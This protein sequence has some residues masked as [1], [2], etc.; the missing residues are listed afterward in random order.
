MAAPTQAGS[1]DKGRVS[2]TCRAMVPAKQ[3]GGSVLLGN[4]RVR[5]TGGTQTLRC[6]TVSMLAAEQ[7]G[8]P[9][10]GSSTP[11][12]GLGESAGTI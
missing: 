12:T 11:G 9:H 2:L 4:W 1:G 8:C 3:D 6:D 5:E 7:M 10:S